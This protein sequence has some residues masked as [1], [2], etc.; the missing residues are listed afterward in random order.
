MAQSVFSAG[1]LFAIPSGATPTPLVFG[2][3]QDVSVDFQFDN[4]QLLPASLA[5]P[6]RS[7][8]TGD[9]PGLGGGGTHIHYHD[10]SG[11]L[12]AD[13][14]RANKGAFVKMLKQAHREFAFNSRFSPA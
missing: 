3:L 4:K 10:H 11:R 1:Y 9:G 7:A 14:I 5:T 12:T 8:L 6:L 2:A 13:Q